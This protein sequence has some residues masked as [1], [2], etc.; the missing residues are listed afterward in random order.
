MRLRSLRVSHFKG[1]EDR[2]L[3]FPENGVIVIEGPNEIGKSTL[4]EALHLLLGELDSSKKGKVKSAQPVDRDV[5]PEVEAE[6][7]S[8]PYRFRYF[9]RFL[10][11][12][13]TELHIHAP[14][15]HD[16]VG[17]PAHERVNAILDE[18]MDR[19]LW[20]ALQITQTDPLTQASLAN[21]QSLAAA[22][23]RAAGQAIAGERETTLFARI[24]AEYLRYYTATGRSGKALQEAEAHESGA[25]A[26]VRETADK[27]DELEDDVN[28][29]PALA[30]REAELVQQLANQRAGRDERQK[31]LDDLIA[32][33]RK[34][35][36][37]NLEA[38]AATTAETATRKAHEARVQRI[39][40]VDSARQRFSGLET[41]AAQG[42]PRLKE[43]EAAARKA[44]EAMAQANAT[45]T[46]ARRIAELRDRDEKH[47][48]FQLDLRKMRDRRKDVDADRELRAKAQASLDANRVDEEM[49]RRIRQAHADLQR[50][51]AH[52]E[53]RS[54]QLT[55]RAR[56]DLTID[57]G[58]EQQELR[59]NAQLERTVSDRL[60]LSIDGVLELEFRGGAGTR[61]SQEA[62]AARRTDFDELLVETRLKSLEEAE[63][64]LLARAESRL[65]IDQCNRQIERSLDDIPYENLVE[66][67]GRVEAKAERYLAE[68]PQDPPPADDYDAA[69]R[70]NREAR[71]AAAAADEGQ[72]DARARFDVRVG[73]REKS[74]GAGAARPSG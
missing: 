16:L 30:D 71:E 2:T 34:L 7:E 68:R 53:A 50:A 15:K 6:I 58:G 40:E 11:K 9:K 46:E 28:A 38:N 36:I 48:H 22:L 61:E 65:V 45:A 73:E 3:E 70:A 14:M 1:I 62:V 18:T 10:K 51:E 44:D 69:A 21:A 23:D 64:A 8:G 74:A 72:R 60:S 66:R 67:I 33:E 47:L 54:A 32:Q 24:E 5:G 42:E 20:A 25:A 12:P 4:L 59:K 49:A 52:A 43:A 41:L 17:R 13:V 29:I 56:R 55:L 27:L 57:I 31:E 19:D 63:A 35:Q 39:A 37:L 26:T